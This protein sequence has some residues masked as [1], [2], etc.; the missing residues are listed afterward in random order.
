MRIYN[1]VE[2]REHENG[3]KGKATIKLKQSGG[4]KEKEIL[5][6]IHSIEEDCECREIYPERKCLRN[7]SWSSAIDELSDPSCIL[8]Q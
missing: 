5:T 7:A 1:A 6:K 3:N 4:T 2:W 8:Q